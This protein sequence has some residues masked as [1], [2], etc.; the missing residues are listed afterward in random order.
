MLFWI[1]AAFLTLCAC[2]AVLLPVVRARGSAAAD[3]DFDLEVYQDQLAE[4]DR[5]VAR[6]VI[7]RAEA[8][9][10][11]AEIARRILKLA[12]ARKVG[13]RAAGA[14]IGRVVATLAVLAVPLASWGMYAAIGS[15]HLPAQPLQAR[16]DKNPAENTIDELV[17]RA[18]GHLAANPGDGRGW[19][20]LAPIYYRMG[21]Y[22]DAAVAYRNAIRLEGASAARE[23]GLGEA[24]AANAG[25]MITTD[26]QAAFERA[27]ALE[28]ENP[29]AQFLL[30]TG[31]AQEGKAEEAGQAWRAMLEGLAP[32]SP[33]RGAIA[34]ALA[35]VGVDAGTE[36]PGPTAQEMEAAALMSDK[37]RAGMIEDMVTGLDQRL[38]D[39]PQDAE[40]W[41]RLV[42]S[43]LVLGRPDEA[44][45]ALAR[46]LEALGPGSEAA[47]ELV[48][49]A[50]ERGVT[51]DEQAGR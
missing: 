11:R 4:L 22:N 35:Q 20:V 32:D 41:R 5:D 29:K 50:A 49:F 42:Q 43:Y 1:V 45:D 40:G 19:E 9:Q 6:N 23:V 28:P 2:L 25:G 46:G 3:T 8:E 14:R 36:R 26:A 31:L 38:R 27:L 51:L 7:D 30:A 48:A 34:Q 24:I 37:D 15:P 39:N 12:G 33:W 18:E 44:G 13:S 16:L 10:A 21:R 47:G 17:A